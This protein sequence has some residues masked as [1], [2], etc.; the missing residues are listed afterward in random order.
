M[1]EWHRQMA[2]NH[3]LGDEAFI[4]ALYATLLYVNSMLGELYG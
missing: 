3:A 4:V 2:L 1:M